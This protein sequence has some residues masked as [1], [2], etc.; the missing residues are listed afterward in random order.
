MLPDMCGGGSL[1]PDPEEDSSEVSATEQELRMRTPNN[2]FPLLSKG[3]GVGPP[4]TSNM[5]FN[6]YTLKT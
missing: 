2:S 4:V 5:T 3:K 1:L 6:T